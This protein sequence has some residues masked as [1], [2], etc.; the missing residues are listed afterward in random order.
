MAANVAKGE[1]LQVLRSLIRE[2]RHVKP[3]TSPR[4]LMAY[5]YVMEKYKENHVTQDQVCRPRNAMLHNAQTYLCL[6]QSTRECEELQNVYRRGERSVEESA[7]LV[8]LALPKP[9]TNS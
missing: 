9:P 1:A 8:G 2:F 5:N 4:N 6:L 3:D 7:R